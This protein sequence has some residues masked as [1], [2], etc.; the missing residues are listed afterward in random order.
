MNY[1]NTHNIVKDRNWLITKWNVQLYSTYYNT[2]NMAQPHHFIKKGINC[3]QSQTNALY[4][5]SKVIFQDFDFFLQPKL[6]FWCFSANSSI[7]ILLYYHPSHS[8]RNSQPIYLI[9]S[10]TYLFTFLTFILSRTSLID[11]SFHS[12]THHSKQLLTK[13]LPSLLWPFVLHQ[14]TLKMTH[15]KD[16]G[17]FAISHLLYLTLHLGKIITVQIGL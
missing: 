15:F 10:T 5:V 13:L 14:H 4:I 11:T 9:H 8:Y 3:F 6:T 12:T 16:W 1:S 7:Q 17:G 2:N